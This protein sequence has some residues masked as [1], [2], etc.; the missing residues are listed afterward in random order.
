MVAVVIRRGSARLVRLG[1]FEAAAEAARRLNADLDMLAGR[2]L[3]ARLDAVIKESVG[4]QAQ[5][6]T[7]EIIA[8]LRS[9]LGDDGVVFVPA[10]PLAGIP[11][12]RAARPARPPGQ[13]VPFGVVLAGR[14]APRARRDDAAG[15]AVAGGGT[16]PGARGPGSHRDRQV[17]P[18]LPPAAP[19]RRHRQRR[20]AGSRRRPGRPPGRARAPRSGE[21]P[22]LQD[23]PGRWPARGLRHPAAG[24]RSP[25]RGPVSLRCRTDGRAS[26]RGDPGLHPP[27]CSTSAPRR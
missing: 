6:L 24:S 23:R 17:L 14:L 19:G 10:G 21:F 12:E 2:R 27:P 3:P 8:P 22:V 16:G 15:L 25:A 4:H 11:L 18:G 1:D 26:R 5:T 13:R 7:A 9:S 20:V